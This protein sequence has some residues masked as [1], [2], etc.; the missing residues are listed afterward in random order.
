[1]NRLGALGMCFGFGI[2]VLIIAGILM[3]Q[4]QVAAYEHRLIPSDFV[5]CFE[6]DRYVKAISENIK[7]D[8]KL[9]KMK[10]DYYVACMNEIRSENK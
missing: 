3:W 1:M 8:S 10:S 4:E 9:A 6:D 7:D 5:S 2:A